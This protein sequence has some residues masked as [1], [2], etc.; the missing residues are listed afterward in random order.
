M[1]TGEQ[2]IVLSR[3]NRRMLSGSGRSRGC[4][5][6]FLRGDFLF[7]TAETECGEGD[8][9][10]EG[11]GAAF[12]EA[13]HELDKHGLLVVNSDFLIEQGRCVK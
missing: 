5:L 6:C 1:Q 10:D 9:G 8:G 7:A 11:R 12:H 2:G 4:F 13:M 3:M